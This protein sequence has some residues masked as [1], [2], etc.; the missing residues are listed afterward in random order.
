M[1]LLLLL[2]LQLDRLLHSGVPMR[3]EVHARLETAA[4]VLKFVWLKRAEK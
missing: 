2:S 1:L 4:E 3:P